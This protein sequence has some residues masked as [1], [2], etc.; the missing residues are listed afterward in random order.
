MVCQPTATAYSHESR[1]NSTAKYG[2]QMGNLQEVG[3]VNECP[4]PDICDHMNKAPVQPF[5]IMVSAMSTCIHVLSLMVRKAV[6][7]EKTTGGGMSRPA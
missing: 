6:A 1:G 2:Y 7:V 3:I 4:Q 5:H